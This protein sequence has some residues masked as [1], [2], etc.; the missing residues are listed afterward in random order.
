M[1]GKHHEA[2]RSTTEQ[3]LHLA[4]ALKL[5][6]LPKDSH[7]SLFKL[8]LSL[9][10]FSSCDILFSSV[11]NLALHA[12]TAVSGQTWN[13]PPLTPTL[14]SLENLIN[15]LNRCTL[16]VMGGFIQFL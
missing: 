6:R 4:I 5:N 14:P 9:Y 15:F 13:H 8:S 1:G 3:Y 2:I 7:C 16:M 10:F 12:V 11:A